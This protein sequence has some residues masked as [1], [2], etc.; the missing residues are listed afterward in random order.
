M[1]NDAGNAV[2]CSRISLDI[3][4][5]AR[6]GRCAEERK[7]GIMKLMQEEEHVQLHLGMHPGIAV[8]LFVV[9][10]FSAHCF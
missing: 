7:K 2:E 5:E 10:F 1:I 8:F 9:N 4:W 3:G 6:M